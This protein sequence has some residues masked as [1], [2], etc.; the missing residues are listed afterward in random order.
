MKYTILTVLFCM[1]FVAN[2]HAAAIPVNVPDAGATSAL[3]V[4]GAMGIFAAKRYF[5]RRS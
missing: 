2:V 5:G 3:L 1:S 4:I